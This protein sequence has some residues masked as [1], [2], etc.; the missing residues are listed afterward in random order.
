MKACNE[1]EKFI[2]AQFDEGFVPELTKLFARFNITNPGVINEIQISAS[3]TSAILYSSAQTE[4]CLI[5]YDNKQYCYRLIKES[6]RCYLQ[7]NGSRLSYGVSRG[8][9]NFFRYSGNNQS[10]NGKGFFLLFQ[11]DVCKVC[12]GIKPVSDSYQ[13]AY[14]WLQSS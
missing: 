7:E 10:I 9:L 1:N 5:D 12:L 6:G 3:N 2:I 4:R 13:C 8:G 14:T 11:G